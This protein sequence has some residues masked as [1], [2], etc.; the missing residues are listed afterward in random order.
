MRTGIFVAAVIASMLLASAAHAASD[1]ASE[2]LLK[3]TSDHAAIAGLT[4]I[5]RAPHKATRPLTADRK[6]IHSTHRRFD[7]ETQIRT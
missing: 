5:G 7:N 4:L 2:K 1:P 6:F 3:S